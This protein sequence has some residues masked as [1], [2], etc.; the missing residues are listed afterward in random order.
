MPSSPSI[1]E[2]LGRLQAGDRDA[3]QYLWERYF[4][5]L[6]RLA[7][8]RLP[9]GR[10]RAMDEEDVALS[11]LDSFVRGV[12]RGRFPDLHERRGLWPLLVTITARKVGKLARRENS[13]RRGGGAVQGESALI[14]RGEREGGAA[15]DE[16]LGGEPSPAFACQVADECARLLDRLDDPQLRQ[17]ALWKMEGYTNGEAAAKLGCVESTVERKLRLIRGIW[18]GEDHS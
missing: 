5:Q 4:S 3:A 8:Q 10:R 2:W 18:A 13:L 15:W 9:A 14:P 12:E 1:T 6:V 7:R 16:I 17:L 11:A